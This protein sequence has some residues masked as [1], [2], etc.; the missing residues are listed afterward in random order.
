M[1]LLTLEDKKETQAICSQHIKAYTWSGNP[2]VELSIH[3]D[4]GTYHIQSSP[5]EFA[6]N[7]V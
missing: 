1:T 7:S 4:A 2:Y 6:A 5:P 3:K